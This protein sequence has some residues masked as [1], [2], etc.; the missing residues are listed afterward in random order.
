M[1]FDYNSFSFLIDWIA[2]DEF[3]GKSLLSIMMNKYS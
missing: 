3:Q 2:L 1:G